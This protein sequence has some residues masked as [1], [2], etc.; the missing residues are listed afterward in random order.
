MS[1]VTRCGP[2]CRGDS[3]AARLSQRHADR[4][5][6]VAV[7][8]LASFAASQRAAATT[9][10]W[11]HGLIATID[12]QDGKLVLRLPDRTMTFPILC[13]PAV[14]ALHRGAIADAD[15]LPGLDHAD[16]TVLIKRLLREA[17]V[18]PAGPVDPDAPR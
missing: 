12:E 3:T 5:R 16:A 4:T 18:V 8:P 7:R 2:S 14:N 13:A 15:S 11:R 9:V 10:V 6:P 1:R 17:V